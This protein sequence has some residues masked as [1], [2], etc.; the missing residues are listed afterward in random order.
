MHIK[1]NKTFKL[2]PNLP[3]PPHYAQICTIRILEIAPVIET[4]E[5]SECV[6][7]NRKGGKENLI[8]GKI[9]RFCIGNNIF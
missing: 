5:L 7:I 2:C 8:P 4:R 6:I 1:D 3:F 9:D